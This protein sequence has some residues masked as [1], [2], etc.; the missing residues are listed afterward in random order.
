MITY[1]IILEYLLPNNNMKLS[2]NNMKLSNNNMKLS[3]NNIILPNNN[4]ILPTVDNILTTIFGDSFTI[5]PSNTLV[6]CITYCLNECIIDT[7][8]LNNT[9]ADIWDISN[10]YHLNIIIFD[11]VNN[12][13]SSTYY[14]EYFNP[15]RPTIFLGKTNNKW[16]NIIMN[17]NTIFFGF[18]SSI[19]KNNILSLEIKKYNSNEDIVI[20]DNFIEIIERDNFIIEDKIITTVIPSPPI[21]PTITPSIIPSKLE[22][23]KKDELLNILTKMNI[24][25]SS[26]K[27]TKKDLIELI[28]KG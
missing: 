28:C 26:T 12:K 14:G 3:N 19:L 4:I 25:I 1:E 2:N 8:D 13:I 16:D 6:N 17:H 20:C 23:L 9:C 24:N 27:L 5:I 11:L 7:H 10:K 15:W 22:K 18:P 21:T